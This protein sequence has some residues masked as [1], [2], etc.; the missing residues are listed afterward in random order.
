MG[1]ADQ[2]GLNGNL[3]YRGSM[4]IINSPTVAS[5]LSGQ[6]R[7]AQIAAHMRDEVFARWY[8]NHY[9]KN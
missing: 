7:A 8:A 9:G 5:T 2:R 6:L 1:C 3:I 4:T